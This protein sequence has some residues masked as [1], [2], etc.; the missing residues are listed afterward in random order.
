MSISKLTSDTK[1]IQYPTSNS[2]SSSLT[3]D[4]NLFNALS[5]KMANAD[6][7]CKDVAR[8]VRD[9][10]EK[11]ANELK[12]RGEL[13]KIVRGKAVPI[14]VDSYVRGKVSSGVRLKAMF[15]VIDQKYL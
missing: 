9:E 11:E 6:Q 7:W 3:I 2:G 12:K 10:L 5:K 8:E 4:E 15:E 1:R 14:T 13:V